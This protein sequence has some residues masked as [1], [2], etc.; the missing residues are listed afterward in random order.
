M[1]LKFVKALPA[2]KLQILLLRQR[3]PP[4]ALQSHHIPFYGLTTLAEFTL[5][6]LGN[7]IE[8]CDLYGLF[9][10]NFQS[11]FQAD[12]EQK[13]TKILCFQSNIY[14]KETIFY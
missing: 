9:P 3:A 12:I 11:P 1:V 4:V 8:S 14:S 7:S 2:G 6:V 13:V 5:K 10:H